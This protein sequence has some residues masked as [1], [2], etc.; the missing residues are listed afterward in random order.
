[1]DGRANPSAPVSRAVENLRNLQHVQESAAVSLNPSQPPTNNTNP[2]I[3]TN[4]KQKRQPPKRKSSRSSGFG[5]TAH[6]KNKKSEAAAIRPTESAESVNVTDNVTSMPEQPLEL[7]D[8]QLKRKIRDKYKT[9]FDL[10]SEVTNRISSNTSLRSQLAAKKVELKDALAASRQDKKTANELIHSSMAQANGA[11]QAAEDKVRE[12]EQ[13][14]LTAER[15]AT[16]AIH[17]ERRYSSTKL[18]KAHKVLEREQ[19]GNEA[20]LAIKAKKLLKTKSQLVEQKTLP[21]TMVRVLKRKHGEVIV[22]MRAKER[23]RKRKQGKLVHQKNIMLQ[24]NKDKHDAE[25]VEMQG[26][27][28]DMADDLQHSIDE[29][30]DATRQKKGAINYA[31]SRLS[32]MRESVIKMNALKDDLAK[33]VSSI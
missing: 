9:I 7:T 21:D 15:D 3:G 28:N 31:N 23:E 10:R 27:L 22:S 14:K 13:V 2:S 20:T 4:N 29:A 8:T 6:G 26:F 1:M 17:A 32:K 18:A 19:R 25:L 12:A 30:A 24:Q 16:C 11:K 33:A 5:R